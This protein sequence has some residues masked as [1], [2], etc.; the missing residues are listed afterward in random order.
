MITFIARTLC[1]GFLFAGTLFGQTHIPPQMLNQGFRTFHELLSLANDAHFPDQVAQNVAWMEKAFR[2]RGFKVRRLETPTQPLLLAEWRKYPDKKTALIYLQIDGQPVDPS[3]WNQPDPFDPTLKKID[4]KGETILE[5]DQL[6]ESP[7]PNWRIF[8]RSASDAKG[9][10]AMLLTSL[11][12][13]QSEGREPACN[14][15]VIMD[16]EEE[17]SSP[18]FTY[19]ASAYAKE[20]QAD[21]LVILD[22]PRHFSNQPTLKFGARGIT[23]LTLTVFGPK[24]PQHSGHFGNYAPNPAFRLSQLLASMKDDAGR[25]LIPGYYD[26]VDLDT[27]TLRL[28]REVPDDED[29]LQKRLGIAQTDRVGSNYQEAL[30]YP[31]L[32]IRGMKSGWVGKEARTIVPATATAELDIRFVP[33]TPPAQLVE[34]VK[35]FI[36]D[37]GY[38]LVEDSPDDTTREKYTHIASLKQSEAVYQSFR[39]S[40]DSEVGKWLFRAL[41][42][43]FGASPIRLRMTGGSIPLAPIVN[44]LGIPAVIVPTVNA[45][46]NQHSPNENLR[47]GNFMEGI[48]SCRAFLL[49]EF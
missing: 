47:V 34:K 11:D 3:R 6:Y 8:A 18:S 25:V 39:T 27:S 19:G 35:K 10:V 33:E 23:T 9:P 32:N 40:W 46:N 42:K 43:E 13:I 44:D 4:K 22:G 2:E 14:L 16:F 38:V 37:Q 12:W 21:G 41:S 1:L 48:Q 49:T 20:L 17:I 29:A 45:D 31:S 15:K 26:G 36:E 28:L 30:Q 5:W 7:D 24:V